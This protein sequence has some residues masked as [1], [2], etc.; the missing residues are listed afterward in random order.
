MNSSIFL[1]F[2]CFAINFV[3]SEN[4]FDKEIA[5]I[6]NLDKSYLEISKGICDSAG[7]LKIQTCDTYAGE[8]KK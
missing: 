7:K 1:C 4:K 2:V 8:K 3:N 5:N 6:T